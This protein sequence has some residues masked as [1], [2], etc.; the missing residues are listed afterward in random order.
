MNDCAPMLPGSLALALG[1][2]TF[3]YGAWFGYAWWKKSRVPDRLVTESHLKE[4][5]VA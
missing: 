5:R 2:L 4:Q 1:M 3:F